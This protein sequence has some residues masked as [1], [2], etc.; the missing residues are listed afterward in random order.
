MD[1]ARHM[2]SHAELRRAKPDRAEFRKRPR[3]PITV[4]LDGVQQ[5][6]NIGA[7]FRLCDAFLV[8]RLVIAGRATDL[9]NRKLVKAARGTQR[10]VPWTAADNAFEVVKAAKNFGLYVI[11]A[12]QTAASLDPASLAVQYPVLLVLGGETSGI[13][14]Q[15]LD[16]A[17]TI[18]AV[19][20]LGMANNLNVSTAAA[21]LLYEISRGQAD[22]G[23]PLGFGDSSH[24]PRE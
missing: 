10:W 15:I 4:L 3:R 13:S 18:I 6:H 5:N 12:E 8:Q 14:A 1:T 2:L 19:P 9:G 7:I 21:I 24:K 17:D 20:M 23:L 16:W 11:A 22:Q